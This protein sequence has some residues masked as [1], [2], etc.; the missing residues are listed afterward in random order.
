MARTK[1]HCTALTK[2]MLLDMGISN[3]YVENKRWV[4]ERTWRK[5]GRS[6]KPVTKRLKIFY[7]KTRHK[8]APTKYYAIVGFSYNNMT[9]TYPLAR[10]L[11]VWFK[12]DIPEGYTVDH[13]DNN[14]FNNNLRNLQLLTLKE[15][16]EKRYDDNP[17]G[18][19]NQY[20]YLNQVDEDES[21]SL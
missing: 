20:G 13:I 7:N 12:G 1:I 8:Y 19:H 18:K 5:V 6:T 16:L 9:H 14:P 11:Y 4:I 3:V 2:Q 21:N 17:D 15:N 10:F